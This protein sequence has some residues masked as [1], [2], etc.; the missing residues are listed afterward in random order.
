MCVFGVKPLE[1]CAQLLIVGIL[2]LKH[3]SALMGI[4][5]FVYSLEGILVID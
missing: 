5:A 3:E 2:C 4:N 1:S